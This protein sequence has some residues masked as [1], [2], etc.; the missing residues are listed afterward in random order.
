MTTLGNLY[1]GN[2]VP[3]DS[4]MM[5][6]NPRYKEGLALIGRLQQELAETLNEEQKE[7]FEKYLTAANELSVV[8]D[9][10]VFKAG[11]RLATKIMIE[12][13]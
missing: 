10:E 9:E 7:L 13:M 4:E 1:N 11:Y 3:C 6:S 8:I 2:I 12:C 5:K